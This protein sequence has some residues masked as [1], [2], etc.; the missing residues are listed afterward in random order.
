MERLVDQAADYIR[1]HGLAPAAMFGYSM[2]GYVALQ[3]AAT[4]PELVRAVA[5]VHEILAERV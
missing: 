4:R 3:L 2:G 5:Q 1:T